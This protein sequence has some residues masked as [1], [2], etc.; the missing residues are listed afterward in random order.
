MRDMPLE[1]VLLS[2]LPAE[3]HKFDMKE[4]ECYNKF[5]PKGT[6]MPQYPLEKGMEIIDA[7]QHFRMMVG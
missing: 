3:H 5:K 2:K 7:F 6:G 1:V 4:R